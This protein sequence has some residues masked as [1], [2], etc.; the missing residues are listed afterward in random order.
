MIGDKSSEQPTL[1][2]YL[3]GE[4]LARLAQKKLFGGYEVPL[5]QFLPL[6]LWLF[7]KGAIFGWARRDKLD[8]VAK[9]FVGLEA[10]RTL[11]APLGLPEQE[12]SS[13]QWV[14]ASL[15]KV[16]SDGIRYYRDYHRKEP[17][18]LLDLLLTSF[19]PREVDF[20][21]FHKA[22]GLAKKKIRLGT[23]LQQSD[24]WLFVGIS[25]GAI[26]PELTER[27]WR[28]SYET[29]D[30]ESWARAWRAGLNIPK[31]FTPLPLE[32]MEHEVL[33]EVASYTSEYFPDL[34][35]P[36]NLRLHRQG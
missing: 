21:D 8:V 23:A 14:L 25:L 32:E 29:A 6:G 36:L 19:A 31:E 28:Q 13:Y 5:L 22:K 24:S 1:A 35:D 20:R 11:L 27:M 3:G 33:V 7:G 15:R 12:A 9:M 18:S 16:A 17:E 2:E 34:V 10:I 4:Q 26:F 30:H